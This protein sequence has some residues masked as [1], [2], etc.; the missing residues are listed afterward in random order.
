MCRRS[1]TYRY[2]KV[3]LL[4]IE[5]ASKMTPEDSLRMLGWSMVFTAMFTFGLTSCIAAPYGKFMA[6]KGW[7][8]LIPAR[9]AWF[10]MESPNLFMPMIVSHGYLGSWDAGYQRLQHQH[11]NRWL[12]TMYQLHYIHRSIIYPLFRIN[13]ICHKPMPL[14]VMLMAFSYCIWNGALQS[15]SLL[16]VVRYPH[17]WL[18]QW[19]VGVGL[20]VYFI[21]F[22]INIRSD[23]ILLTLKSHAGNSSASTKKKAP[24]SERY[25]IPYGGMFQY[26]S[27]ANYFGEVVEWTGYAL[28]SWSLA[29]LAF[30]VFTFGNL[31]PRAR[32]HQQFYLD[33]FEE[34]PSHRTA[35][36]PFIL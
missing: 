23:A 17:D 33:N 25:R 32:R 15:L 18:L 34:Y 1:L 22:L 16:V 8:M 24:P 31:A 30:A 29:G 27:C 2:C 10:V 3:C 36:V 20:V 5:E 4:Q 12:F 11:A 9:L 14:S 7:G 6:S 26:V 35:I 19:N 28:A 21:G 13:G